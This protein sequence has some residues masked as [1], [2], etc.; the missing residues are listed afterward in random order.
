MN[1]ETETIKTAM[2][3]IGKISD[4]DV[5]SII[6]LAKHPEWGVSIES[7]FSQITKHDLSISPTSYDTIKLMTQKMAWTD[8]PLADLKKLVK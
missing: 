6:G 8:V 5:N 7:L 4:N 3:Y 1:Y 2:E